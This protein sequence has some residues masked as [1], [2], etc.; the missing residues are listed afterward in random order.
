MGQEIVT[1]CDGKDEVCESDAEPPCVRVN[2]RA[3][4]DDREENEGA[5]VQY[6]Y[7]VCPFYPYEFAGDVQ[8]VRTLCTLASK[9][10]SLNV[11]ES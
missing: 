4:P 2:L 5:I 1:C 7:L 10:I 11:G 3:V 8:C 9:A 6:D